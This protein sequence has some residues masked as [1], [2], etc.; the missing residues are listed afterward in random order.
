MDVNQSGFRAKH[1]TGATVAKLTDDICIN[2]NNS[3]PTI[4]TLIDL[5][6]AFDTINHSILIKKLPHFGFQDNATKWIENYLCNRKQ[7]TTANNIKSS[8]LS[9]TY[10]VP[11]GSILGS[12]LFLLYINDIGKAIKHCNYLLYADDIVLYTANN[13]LTITSQHMNEDLQLVQQWCSDNSLTINSKKTK[14]MGFS[15]INKNI[16][17]KDICQFKLR[18]QSLEV[19]DKYKYLGIIMDT[20]LT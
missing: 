17:F 15:L 7:L 4:A 11:Q 9:V 2:I 3:Q 14:V 6:K 20:Q 8:L 12:S 19:V 13:N 16:H 1:S 5:R 18:N 10:G